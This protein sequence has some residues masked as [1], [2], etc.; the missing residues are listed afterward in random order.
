MSSNIPITVSLP[1]KDA[2]VEKLLNL[3][4]IHFIDIPSSLSSYFPFASYAQKA[5]ATLGNLPG[6]KFLGLQ[7]KKDRCFL[8]KPKN[9]TITLMKTSKLGTEIVSYNFTPKDEH[10]Q[11]AVT[12]GESYFNPHMQKI[13]SAK[14]DAFETEEV[15]EKFNFSSINEMRCQKIRR[16]KNSFVYL[17]EN[18]PSFKRVII[19]NPQKYFSKSLIR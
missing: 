1:E 7:K 18:F 9:N 15:T 16:L 8:E 13:L 5:F 12:L 14:E 4:S 3:Q 2:V 19:I 6:V 10:P 17:Q 11:R